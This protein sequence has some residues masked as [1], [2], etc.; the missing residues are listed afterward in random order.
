M[1][2]H[3]TTLVNTVYDFYSN[4][5][6]AVAM[7]IPDADNMYKDRNLGS[8]ELSRYF[9]GKCSV[10]LIFGTW[11]FEETCSLLQGM[12]ECFLEAQTIYVSLFS[13]RH[14]GGTDS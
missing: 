4:L 11:L 3:A 14:I 12:M 5:I 7:E 6:T 9:H 2:R 10:V 1:Q 8:L 13:L